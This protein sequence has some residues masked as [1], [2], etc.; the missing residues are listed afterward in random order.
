[1]ILDQSSCRHCGC[2]YYL[3][4]NLGRNGSKQA[5]S[6]QELVAMEDKSIQYS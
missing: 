2:G 4:N 5:S 1:M 6:S 3:D